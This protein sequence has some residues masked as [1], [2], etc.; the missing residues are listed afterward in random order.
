MSQAVCVCRRSPLVSPAQMFNHIHSRE[1]L[2]WNLVGW[3]G[4]KKNKCGIKSVLMEQ[5]CLCAEGFS[6]STTRFHLTDVF[7]QT[8]ANLSA[9]NSGIRAGKDAKCVV[10]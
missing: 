5:V 6:F 1:A 8:G 9:V 3:G 2:D 4:K 7:I 10:S